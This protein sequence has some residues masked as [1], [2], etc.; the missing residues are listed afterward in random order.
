MRGSIRLG[1][2]GGIGSGKSTVAAL[3]TEAG[4]TVIDA[5]AISRAITGAGGAALPVIHEAFGAHVFD[6]TGALDRAAMRALVSANPG[7]RQRLEAIVHPIVMQESLRQAQAAQQRGAQ[8]IVFDVPLLAESG[9][10]WRAQLDAVLVVDCEPEEQIAR[11]AARSG[12]PRAHIEGIMAAQAARGERLAAA[13]FVIFNG[14]GVSLPT[15]R[16]QV[17]A[18]LR[19]LMGL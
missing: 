16:A 3:L 14:S 19:R 2:T 4:A 12:W 1:L 7:A 10:R 6:A 11:V 13:D 17:Q 5:D 8:L 15:L 18:L 9:A